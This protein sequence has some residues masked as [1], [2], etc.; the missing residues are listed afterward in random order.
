[1]CY[2]CSKE[3]SHQDSSF[4]YPQQKFLLR[5]KKKNF[6]YAVLSEGLGR[7]ICPSELANSD[8]QWESKN[9]C[10]RGNI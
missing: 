8:N 7:A 6:S 1:M 2:G 10:G 5:N 3:P 4:E 9:E